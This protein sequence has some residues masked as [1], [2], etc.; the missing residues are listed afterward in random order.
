MMSMLRLLSVIVSGLAGLASIYLI[1]QPNGIPHRTPL[2]L[3]SVTLLLATTLFNGIASL[4]S[5]Q[6][7]DGSPDAAAN[8]RASAV[9]REVHGEVVKIIAVLGS[10]VEAANIFTDALNRASA[11][12]PD[13]LKPEQVRLVISYLMIENEN[14]RKRTSDM[15]INLEQ[16]QRQIEKLKSNLA[17]AEAQGL[18]DPLTGLKNRRGFDITLAA[19]IAGART[20]GKPMS[21]VI[22][23]IDHFKSIN[24]RY[25]HPTGDEVLKWF[26]KI[27][28]ANMKGRDTVARYGG[29]EFAI[30]LPQTSLE[31]AVT[32]AGQIRQQIETHLW[33]KPGAPNTMLKITASFG[34][35]QL[36]DSEGTSGLINRADAKLYASKSGGRN[37]VAA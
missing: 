29:E 34:V 33:K 18:T 1:L 16:S 27:L 35:A 22:T 6:T 25:G 12:L 17:A 8:A 4:L 9:D 10:Q 13:G 2:L 37:R 11:Q 20:A 14:M 24:D 23:D 31:N 26:A 36:N 3:G 15:Q 28:S 32:L 5:W 7:A 21:L 30:I 19:E